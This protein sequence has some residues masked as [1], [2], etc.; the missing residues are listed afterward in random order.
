MIKKIDVIMFHSVGNA[1]SDWYRKW[2]SVATNHFEYLCRYFNKKRIRTILL[3]EWYYLQDNPKEITGKEVCLTFDDGYLDNLAYADKILEKYNSKGTIFINPEFAGSDKLREEYLNKDLSKI[4]KLNSL[5]HLNWEEIKYLHEKGNMDIQSHSM[6]HNF[7]F[8]SDK[9][10]DI[11]SG[12]EE[13]DWLAWFLSPSTK[14][15]YLRE[16]QTNLIPAGYPIFHNYRA[17]GLKRYFP[18]DEF[19]KKAIELTTF[20]S[21]KEKL[22][23]ELKKQ[24]NL[25]PGTYETEQEM[26]DRYRYELFESKRI[27]EQN[28]NKRVDFLCWPGGGYNDLSIEISKEAGYKASTLAS[29]DGVIDVDN[30]QKYKR[31]SRFGL[32]S[33][34]SVNTGKTVVKYNKYLVD[35]LLFKNNYYYKIK[36]KVLSLLFKFFYVNNNCNK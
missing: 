31:I 17:L 20:I 19:I 2:L 29:R 8:D 13:Y 3:D 30:S 11:Y 32:G 28:L 25:F 10:I 35:K 15:K 12:Q 1:N 27:L 5:G 33:S 22:L 21:D 24:L 7:Y 23:N 6:S 14:P 16:N 9:L 34:L 26:K 36:L 18:D 4:D